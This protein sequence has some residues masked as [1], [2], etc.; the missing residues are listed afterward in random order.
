MHLG[1]AEGDGD[2]IRHGN[3]RDICIGV[4]YHTAVLHVQTADLGEGSGG[5]IIVAEELGGDGEFVSGVDLLSWTVVVEVAAVLV[6]NAVVSLISA[7][8]E[9]A[10][11]SVR[12]SDA[13]MLASQSVH[14]VATGAIQTIPGLPT[15]KTRQVNCAS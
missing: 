6:T 12:A 5:A 14:L 15:D 4:L 2:V 1:R 13:A 11:T 10:G 8:A 9:G 3:T 7:A